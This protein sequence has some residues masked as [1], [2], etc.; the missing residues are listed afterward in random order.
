MGKLGDMAEVD[1]KYNVAVSTAGIGGL[2]KI[3]V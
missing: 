2:R 3:V 1:A